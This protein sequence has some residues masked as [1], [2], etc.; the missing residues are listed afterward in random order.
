MA[1]DNK[2]KSS[3]QIVE[4]VKKK[5]SEC[6][7]RSVTS[8]SNFPLS[9]YFLS[10]LSVKYLGN[11]SFGVAG[12][13]KAV[14]S[15]DRVSRWWSDLMT[16]ICFDLHNEKEWGTLHSRRGYLRQRGTT[17]GLTSWQLNAQNLQW[18]DEGCGG[19][20]NVLRCLTSWPTTTSSDT[21]WHYTG[22]PL[23]WRPS[24]CSTLHF[25]RCCWPELCW[26][27]EL[28]C[29]FQYRLF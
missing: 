26:L 4:A 15:G 10:A 19:E 2:R 5:G 9:R 14:T 18:L 12:Q 13:F 3:L 6:D 28:F 23:F 8:S 7:W 21:K 22:G 16:V 20:E 11:F 25:I 27:F 29:P 17:E 1:S 24:G